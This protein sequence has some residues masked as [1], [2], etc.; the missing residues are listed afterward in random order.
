MGVLEAQGAHEGYI[1]GMEQM[2]GDDREAV[3]KKPPA[4]R[5][6]EFSSDKERD[7]FIRILKEWLAELARTRAPSGLLNKD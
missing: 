6:P 3:K 2:K 7:E 5:R 1:S 4:R